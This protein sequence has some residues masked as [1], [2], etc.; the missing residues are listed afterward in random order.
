MSTRSPSSEHSGSR[1]L[2]RIAA[3]IP[4]RRNIVVMLCL[5]FASV[6]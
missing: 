5:S 3:A 4:L 6:A 2:L 1:S